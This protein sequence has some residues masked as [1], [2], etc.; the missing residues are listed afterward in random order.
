MQNFPNSPAPTSLPHGFSG[1]GGGGPPY[2]PQPAEPQISPR[3]TDDYAGMQQQSLLRGHHHPSQA[4]HMLAYSA[5]NRAAVEQPPT[6]GNIHSGNSTNPYRKD[7]MDYY[8]SIGGKERQRRGGIGYGAGFGYPNIDGHIPHQYRHA[9]S[10]SAPSPGLM[11]PYPVDYG[12]SAGSG[13][14]AGAGAFSPT[15]QYNMS[16]NPAMQSV[17]VSQMQHRQHGQTFPAVHHGQQHRSYPLSGHR[18]TP[19]YAHYSPQSGASTG[20]SGMYSPPPQRYLDGAASSGF[21]PK[22][23]S[24]P[25]VNST[26][27][28]VS[29][30]V[31]A[32]NVGPMENVQQSY[33]AS[34]YPGYSPQTH[35]LHKQSTLQHRNSQHNLGVGYDNS[36]KMQHQGLSPGSVYAKQPSN[37]SI[38]Q[39]ASQEIAK[40]PMHPNAQQTQ[41][42]QNFSPISNP[43]PAASAVHSPSCS[44]SPSPLMGVS[45]AHGNPSG[46]G[47]SHPPPSN[48]RSSHGHGRL[49]QT[50]PQLS[51][52]PNSNSSISSCGSSGSHKAH[53]MSSVAGRNKTGL[54]AGIGSREDAS[55][56]Y[57]SSLLDKMQDAGLNSL[58]ALSSQVANLPNTVQ[59]M[60]LTDTVLSHK[61]KEVGPM[62]QALHSMPHSHPRSRN[63]S[64]AS[65]TSTVK[66]G[67]ADGAS[68]DAGADE[69]S[70]LMSVGGSSGTKVEREEQFSEGEHGR[71]RQM[72][73]ASSGSETT[74]YHPPPQNQI[75]PQ[76]VQTANAKTVSDSL[77]KE[78]R[79]SELKANEARVPSLSSSP[80]FGCQSSE[81]GPISHSTPPVS[82]SLSSSIPPPQPNCVSEPVLTYND[83]RGGR[84]K[85]TGV[86]NEVIKN[87]S[88]GVVEKA[89]RGSSQMQRDVEVNTQNGQDKENKLHTAS[90]LHNSEREEKHTSE[91]QQSASGVGVIVSARSE[92]SHTEKNKHPQDNC[93]EEKQSH[94]YLRESSSHNGEEGIDLSLYSSQKSNFGRPQNTPQSASHKYGY[95]ES[96]YGSDLSMKKRGR[97]GA[98]SVMESN[99]RYLGYQQSQTGSVAEALVKRGHGTGG[100]VHE[101]NSQMQQFPSLL[102][103]V[104]QGYNLDRRYGRPEQAFPAHLQAQQHIQGRTPYENMRMQSG[105]AEAGKPTHPNLRHGS[106]PDFTTDPQI[107]VKSEVSNANILQNADKPELGVS[108]SHLQQATESQQPPPKHINLADY[109]L[110]QRKV[111]SNVSTPSS[112]VQELLLQE[113]EPLTGSIGQTESQKSSGSILAPSERRSVICD[114]SPNRR[115]TPERERESDREREKSQIGASVIQQPFSSP[116]AANDLSKKDTGEKQVV[117]MEMISKDP[118]PDIVNLQTDRRGRGG[119]NEADMEYHPKSVHSSVVMNADPY[120]RGNVDM[121]PLPSHPMSTNPLSSPS[122][123]QS[124]LHSVD[125]STGS[126]SSFPGYRYGE[127]REG[128]T[129]PRGNPHFPSHHPYH[130]LA[131]QAQSTNKLQM[132]PHPRGLPH[133]P[134]EMSDWVKAM[135]R[136]SKEL[137]M[138]P[139]S[140]PGRHKVGQSEQRTRMIPQTDMPAEQH[141]SK[142]NLHHQGAYF[143]MKMWES[144]HPGREGPR[145]ME[146]EAFYR[147]QPPPPPAPV[148]SHGPAPPQM[149]HGQN[150]AEPEV[151][152]GAKEE[153]KHPGPP[154]PS[155]PAKPPADMNVPPKVRQSKAGG[156]GDTNPL[157]LR[158]RV[159]SFISPIPAKRQLQDVTQPRAASNSHHSPGAHSESSH[160]NEEDSTGSDILCPRLSSPM[161]GENTYSQPQ[162]PSSANTKVLPPKKGRGLKLEAIVQKI[163]PN[164]KKPAGHAEDESNHYPGFS[165]SDAFNDSQDQDLAHF[166]RV[167]GG[168]DSY[169]DDS[170]S[171]NNINP[172]RGVDETGP[173]PPS[174]YPCDPLQTSQALKQQDFDFGLGTS[175]ASA[176]DDKEDFA[177]LG[178]LPP[179]PPLPRP[180]QG[181]PPPS[182]SALSDIQHFTNTYQELETRRGEQSA[183]NLLRQ[184]LQESDMGF[185]DYPGSDY[186]GTTPP[187]HSQG[188]GHMLSRHQM[189][190]GRSSLSPDSKNS[191]SHVPKG[192]FPSGKKKGRPVGSVNKQKRAQQQA[193]TPTQGQSQGQTPNTALSTAPSSPTPSTGAASALQTEL[194]PSCTPAPEEHLM[195]D[196]KITLPLDPPVLTQ[197]VKVD[198]ESE[199]THQE[200]EVKPVRRRRRGV[201]DEDGPLEPRGRQ[202]RRRR[203]GAAAAPS[204]AKDDPDTPLGSGGGRAFTD[205]NRKGPFAPHIHVEN[206]VP[207][208]GAVCT[209]VNAEE[210]KM[211]GER[212]AVAGKAGGSGIDSLLTSALS[213]QVSKRDKESERRSSD[214]EETTLQAGKRLPSSGFVVSG[215]VITETD[216]SGRLLCCLCQKWANYKHLGDLYGP[217]YRAEYAA[218]LPK[219]QPQVRQGQATTGTNKTGANPDMSSNYLST[220][221]DSQTAEAQFPKPVTESDYAISLD[222]NPASLST[223][224][225]T[226]SPAGRE[227][228][229]MHVAGKLSNTAFPYSYSSSSSSS[230]SSTTTSKTKFLTWDMNLDTRPIPQLKRE[231]DLETDP[232]Q[233]QKQLLLQPPPDEA[234]QRPQHRKLTSHP[235]FKRRHKSSEDSPR[236]VP[237]N[238]KASLPFQPPPPALDSL[239]PLA[240]LAQLPQMPMDPEELWVHECCIVWTSGVYL[241]NGRLY[242]LQEALDGARETS[243]SYCE[244]V[245]STLGCYSKGCTLRYHYMC[246]IEADCSLNEDNYSLRCPKHK[247]TQSIRPAKS[248]YLEQSERG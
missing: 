221:Q 116:G 192:Y 157:I 215:S 73:G 239:G 136:S 127:T 62:Q 185:D 93:G 219:N 23:N 178:P 78:Q 163:T 209:I 171:L 21:D 222:S 244:M 184:K 16:Q 160:H 201:K 47:P 232:Q 217:F 123:H 102:Q 60:L 50:M 105:G 138:Q 152:R 81:T 101:D 203:G 204:V 10:G 140:S 176:S 173:L 56:V 223:P 59:H 191:D 99:S 213:S 182:S 150:A 246:A 169:M 68:L 196:D 155:H 151:P 43:S 124:Y 33:H 207:E 200:T 214:E 77:T 34:S 117:K 1:R 89:E 83:N 64:A 9:G 22:V 55:S 211:K 100:K 28:S 7:A 235:R 88:E 238:S 51:P 67:S 144:A 26:S 32:N 72:S 161:S 218:K 174:A 46:H 199:D 165:H 159:R 42:N 145:M 142:P 121:S 129:M 11:S 80:S 202:R 240:Q 170:H 247:S 189:S 52:T 179:P 172:F 146:G 36:L 245:G 134:H 58:N 118:G 236:M 226:A 87:E 14:G 167:T 193:G 38:P 220:I 131:H 53:S 106:E 15:H 92:G 94:S 2:P 153:A 57:S 5:R 147:T 49:L 212:S 30:S 137:M 19:Q 63:A 188:Q 143:D 71:V 231:L 166:P 237:S 229:M 168:N 177:L 69:D 8:F 104:L 132:Y 210:E 12:S 227:D 248:V 107:A 194:S 35:S 31:A 206:K 233:V 234:L 27:N 183:A 228:M 156:S 44:S 186:Y 90:R 180:V 61:K 91:E 45:E 135:N 112:A 128:N 224:V 141:A 149:I 198:V 37:P 115:S 125:L 103:E 126:G 20:S 113:P 95:P 111:L 114:V 3:M 97:A 85:T 242:G 122:R 205:S 24:S 158:R 54:G 190:S 110:P 76:S 48:P 133:H 164:I 84:K 98:A 65:S 148:A 75:Q 17:S 139:G 187:H 195:S 208:I 243:C 241:V 96:T 6:Q 13:G 70:S 154:P 108:Q 4:S 29:S 119:A 79:V 82:S 216:H 39:A 86:K 74:G 25:S 225:R 40:S 175:V 109:S 197:V 120:R 162:S 41:I 230:S 181:S 130:N 18:M 66:D